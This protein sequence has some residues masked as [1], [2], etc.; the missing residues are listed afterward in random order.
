[1]TKS[2]ESDVI[3]MTATSTTTT[4][5]HVIPRAAVSGWCKDASTRRFFV[6]TIRWRSI[7]PLVKVQTV[8]Q[9]TTLSSRSTNLTV[10]CSAVVP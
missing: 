5:R 8:Q 1:M 7:D 6:R 3:T 2:D 4:T 9:Y 10:Q